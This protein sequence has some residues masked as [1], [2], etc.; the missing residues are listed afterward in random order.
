[1][2]MAGFKQMVHDLALK[3]PERR[4][5][6]ELLREMTRR[7]KL[8]AI[9]KERWGLPTAASSRDLVMGR[10]RMHRDGYGFVTPDPDSLPAR[11]QGKLAGDIFIPPLAIGNAMDGDQVLVELGQI[12]DDGRAEGRILRVVDRQHQTVVGKFHYGHRY[13]YVTPS[14]E[15]LTVEIVIPPGMERPQEGD[16]DR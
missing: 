9:G 5:L 6:E 16:E 7:R 2:H 12:R 11:A 14:D 13:N 10:L 1:R 4:R 15:K 8:V 3:G